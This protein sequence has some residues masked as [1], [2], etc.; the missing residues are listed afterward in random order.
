MRESHSMH[1]SNIDF[2]DSFME[3]CVKISVDSIIVALATGRWIFLALYMHSGSL[4]I[5]LK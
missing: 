5:K 4:F 3:V 2:L 1:C